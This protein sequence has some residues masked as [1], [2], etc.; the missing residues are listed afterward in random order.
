MNE[1]QEILNQE[2]I[3]EDTASNEDILSSNSP[4]TLE[5]KLDRVEALLNEEITKREAG[6]DE[7]V[8]EEGQRNIQSINSTD[9]GV[10]DPNYSQYI[11]DLLTDSTIKV[12]IVESQDI[13]EK[14][15]NDYSVSQVLLTLI[16]IAFLVT[17]FTSFLD[18][19][20]FKF[21]RR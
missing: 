4:D 3:L 20:I 11:Y 17:I 6:E 10:S 18:K 7:E 21:R 5:D 15:L 12:E 19:Y 8:L 16:F 13:T 14:S 1:N 2:D 9:S